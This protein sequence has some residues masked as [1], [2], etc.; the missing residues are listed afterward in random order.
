MRLLIF[1]TSKLAA[2][3]IAC[4]I[5]EISSWRAHWWWSKWARSPPN[6]APLGQRLRALGILSGTNLMQQLPL[7]DI[8]AR[9]PCTLGHDCIVLVCLANAPGGRNIAAACHRDISQGEDTV[10]HAGDE[11]HSQDAG[12]SECLKACLLYAPQLPEEV[13]RFVLA[14]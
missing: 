10:K 9:F 14:L 11:L 7:P 1:A 2:F 4:D 5:N 12:S 13:A 6:A 8:S 3:L